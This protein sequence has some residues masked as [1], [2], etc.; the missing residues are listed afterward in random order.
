MDDPM[1]QPFLA[2]V[3]NL[4]SMIFIF[5]TCVTKERAALPT[6]AR[7]AHIAVFQLRT[8]FRRPPQH[9]AGAGSLS[10]IPRYGSPEAFLCPALTHV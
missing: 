8:I 5:T 6:R 2:S 1:E 9:V 4:R 10:I 3:G 7:P